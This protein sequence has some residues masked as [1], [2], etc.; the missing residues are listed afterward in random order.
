ME[1][2][3]RSRRRRR[4]RLRTI[5]SLWGSRGPAEVLLRVLR[6][7][8]P[9]GKFRIETLFPASP[10]GPSSLSSRG[11]TPTC[12]P[13]GTNGS[14][15]SIP[16]RA[17]AVSGAVPRVHGGGARPRVADAGRWRGRFRRHDVRAQERAHRR[18]PGALS[19][20]AERPRSAA[21]ASTSPR[22]G[23]SAPTVLL[24]AAAEAVGASGARL[25][26][27]VRGRASSSSGAG[28]RR[29]AHGACSPASCGR[30]RCSLPTLDL[31]TRQRR[32]GLGLD[33]ST[34]EATPGAAGQEPLAR[35]PRARR[36]GR[37]PDAGRDRRASRPALRALRPQG[38][39][40]D[41]AFYQGGC[42]RAPARRGVPPQRARDPL[43]PDRPRAPRP[44]LRPGT[45]A[46][47]ATRRSRC[48]RGRRR[49]VPR[50]MITDVVPFD[51]APTLLRRSGC[52]DRREFDAD[53]IRDRVMTA[54]SSRPSR[55][56][57]V[58]AWLVVGGEETEVRLPRPPSR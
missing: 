30:P 52:A 11:R 47:R 10:P 17:M 1:L 2:D 20:P 19:S 24:H 16:A 45:A 28:R 33:A 36:G 4:D 46:A 50:H 56:L 26:D 29:A 48:L 18:P 9:T 22:W 43:R 40:I 12:G 15:S 3:D 37:V 39:V 42:D 41:L 21:R 27:G 38:T 25:G 32:P 13:A 6:N 7:P 58:F 53:R 35:D 23:R 34:N 51:E 54:A 14:A 5:R 49:L 8:P 57:F 55:I 44:R 31:A